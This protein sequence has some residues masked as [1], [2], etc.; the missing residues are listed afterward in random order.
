MND[1][2]EQAALFF[3]I[4]GEVHR[5][6]PPDRGERP[7]CRQEQAQPTRH[8]L[9]EQGPTVREE[10]ERGGQA[11]MPG[12]DVDP[13][14]AVL[15]RDDFPVGHGGVARWDDR[16]AAELGPRR[17]GRGSEKK[18]PH[19]CGDRSSAHVADRLNGSRPYGS[20]RSWDSEF[21]TAPRTFRSSP[22]NRRSPNT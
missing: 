2:V 3:P 5:R 16:L 1:Y 12:D 13:D 9:R 19:R 14:L 4:R 6:Q 11:Q 21:R 20:A 18:Q 7:G 10:S 22:R 17:P 15:H 8:P